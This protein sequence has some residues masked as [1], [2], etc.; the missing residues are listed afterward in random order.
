MRP[1]RAPL[2]PLI[3]L[4]HELVPNAEQKLFG[5]LLDTLKRAAN[6]K[7]DKSVV[8]CA[9]MG[10]HALDPFARIHALTIINLIQSTGYAGPHAP[11]P[12]PY[13]TVTE[14][15]RAGSPTAAFADCY[16]WRVL[17][18]TDSI[19]EFVLDDAIKAGQAALVEQMYPICVSSETAIH[20]ERVRTHFEDIVRDG[21]FNS[22]AR[23]VKFL[24]HV[25]GVDATVT[26]KVR[27]LTPAYIDTTKTM[28]IERTV[29]RATE[30]ITG[31]QPDYVGNFP[32]TRV[33]ELAAADLT[34]ADT[35]QQ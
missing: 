6:N 2:Q 22:S 23:T 29:A 25:A 4:W 8:I 31:P 20:T 26:K 12:L 17:R 1:I 7:Y 13:A 28:Y 35:A 9:V 21:A 3:N 34:T 16:L 14:Y 5:I 27:L 32:Y 19:S 15:K 10:D 24:L 30:H 33:G 18:H 11:E